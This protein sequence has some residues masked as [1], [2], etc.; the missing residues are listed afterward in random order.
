MVILYT[1]ILE[2]ISCKPWSLKRKK[3][4]FLFYWWHWCIYLKDA[5]GDEKQ[6]KTTQSLVFYNYTAA[7]FDLNR[8]WKICDSCNHIKMNG[9]NAPILYLG[10]HHQGGGLGQQTKVWGAKTKFA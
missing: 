3:D 10:N 7:P 6:L 2:K 8:Y 9:N 5:D 4:D 1:V